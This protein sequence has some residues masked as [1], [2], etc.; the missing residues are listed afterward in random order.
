[1]L[2]V[3]PC[4]SPGPQVSLKLPYS[5]YIEEPHSYM[6]ITHHTIM[7]NDTA[8]YLSDSD[9]DGDREESRSQGV[10]VQA[11]PKEKNGS[12]IRRLVVSD[13]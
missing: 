5:R 6:P 7:N 4:R 8:A 2:R 12:L 11:L 9:S 3:C 1:M 13:E 10:E